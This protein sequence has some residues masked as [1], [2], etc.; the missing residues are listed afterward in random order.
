MAWLGGSACSMVA[1]RVG[2][3]GFYRRRGRSCAKASMA[4]LWPSSCVVVDG[5]GAG[6][7]E[8]ASNEATRPA[9][10]LQQR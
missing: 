10:M 2:W 4:T 8:G 7:F 5:A 1:R 6:K 9:T 3:G